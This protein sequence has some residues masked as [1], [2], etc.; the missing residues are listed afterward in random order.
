MNLAAAIDA[1]LIHLTVERQLARA[2]VA[3]Y[4]RDLSRFREV[5]ADLGAVE[6]PEVER[7]TVLGYMVHLSEA[8]MSARTQIRHLSSVR[9]LFRYLVR[10]G[11]TASDPTSG[12]ESPE[13]PR[14]LPDVLTVAE[15]D[16]L[17]AA[18]NGSGPLELRDAAALELLYATGLR[19][20]ELLQLRLQDVRLDAGY[21]TA[22]GKGQKQRLVPFAAVAGDKIKVYLERGRPELV[23]RKTDI[24][25]LTRQG[26]PLTRQAFWKLLQGYAKAAGLR[27]RV[28]PHILRHSFATHML[29]RGADL[30]AVQAMLGHADIATTQIYTHVSRVHVVD[31][32]KK[33]HPRA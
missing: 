12:V 33:T 30:R 19:V 23:E 26:G 15:V 27:R 20:S 7:G 6:L 25:F 3:N 1:Y 16:K 13:L 14:A 9:G 10:E 24:L 32:Y 11:L 31:V 28:H 18:P 8:R 29:E 21:L 4:A 2:S 5:A 22:F 17:L